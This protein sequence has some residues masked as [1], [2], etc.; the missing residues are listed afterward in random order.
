[1]S[2]QSSGWSRA[3]AAVIVV[4]VVGVGAYLAHR[5][6]VA[7]TPPPAPAA[8]SASAASAAPSI[9]HPIAQAASGPAAATTAPLPT[10]GQSDTSVADTLAALAGGAD[11]RALLVPRQI[12]A[13]IVATIDALPRHAIGSRILPLRTPQGAFVTDQAG[14]ATVIGDRNAERYAPYMRVVDSVDPKML[15]AWYVRY[16]PLFQQ[17]YRQLGYPK[18]YFNDRLIEVIDNLLA[19]PDLAQPPAVELQQGH[20]VYVD[21][22]LESLS[23]GQKLLLRVGPADAARIKAKLRAIR[24]DLTGA[25]LPAAP[26]AH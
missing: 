3:G 6:M 13:R 2:R 24:A 7:N 26:V 12:I 4:A 20:Y 15:V 17:A 5:A 1:M 8:T 21:P 18:G 11:L 23:V 22:A 10:L 14:G 16:Y 9:R 19:A 25:A